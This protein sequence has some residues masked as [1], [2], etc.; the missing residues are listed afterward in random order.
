MKLTKRG[1]RVRA[2]VLL[3]GIIAT[4]YGVKFYTTHHRVYG[5]CHQSAE[6]WAC[7]LIKWETNKY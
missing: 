6:G 4:G 3:A 1:K 2:L 7:N 5:N